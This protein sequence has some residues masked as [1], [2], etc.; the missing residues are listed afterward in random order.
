M[1]VRKLTVA[2]LGVVAGVVVMGAAAW[3]C[4]SGPA[5]TLSTATARPGQEVGISGTGWRF[6]I[7]PVTTRNGTK[8]ELGS[9]TQDIFTAAVQYQALGSGGASRGAKVVLAGV[10]GLLAVGLVLVAVSKG[11]RRA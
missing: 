6:K 11:S 4:V 2:G 8:G 7:D 10:V 1:G 5:V 3:G 9:G